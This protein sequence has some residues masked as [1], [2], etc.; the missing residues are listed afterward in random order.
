MPIYIFHGTQDETIYYGSSLKLKGE[1]KEKI[2]LITLEGQ[3]HNNVTD[4]PQYIDAIRSIL[5]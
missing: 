1:F 4:N 2:T 3:G 5:N